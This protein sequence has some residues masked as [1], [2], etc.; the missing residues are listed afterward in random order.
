MKTYL[1]RRAGVAL[2]PDFPRELLL[3]ALALLREDE[4]RLDDTEGR[5]WVR[6]LDCIC[7]LRALPDRVFD[8]GRA[9]LRA[10]AVFCRVRAC[11]RAL[12]VGRA[13]AVRVCGACVCG[14]R[15]PVWRLRVF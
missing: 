8:A 6:E 12:C 1:P 2:R 7:E 14:A 13:G 11:G 4:E 3:G 10:G 9:V 5:D 15:V